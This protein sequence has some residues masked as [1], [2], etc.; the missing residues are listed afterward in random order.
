MYFNYSITLRILLCLFSIYPWAQLITNAKYRRR[1][2][3]G[4]IRL[5]SSNDQ[6]PCFAWINQNGISY[7]DKMAFKRIVEKLIQNTHTY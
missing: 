3:C 5:L 1:E 4:I 2:S 6:G 7:I